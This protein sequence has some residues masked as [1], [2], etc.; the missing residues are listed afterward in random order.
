MNMSS[1]EACE[2][3]VICGKAAD[4]MGK[5]CGGDL[6]WLLLLFGTRGAVINCWSTADVMEAFKPADICS[7]PCSS[8][9]KIVTCE[10]AAML[11]SVEVFDVES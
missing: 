11:R 2:E 4:A 8:N 10:I 6:R 1:T 9:M 5:G 3:A 7:T